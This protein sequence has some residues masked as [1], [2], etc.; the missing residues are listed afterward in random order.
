VR[1]DLER[2]MGIYDA[3]RNNPTPEVLEIVAGARAALEPVIE[4][5]AELLYKWH[6][7]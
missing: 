5:H 1:I 6:H 4:I 2:E 7:R 3:L